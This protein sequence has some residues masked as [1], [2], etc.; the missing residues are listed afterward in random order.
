MFTTINVFPR[1]NFLYLSMV[2]SDR[3]IGFIFPGQIQNGISKPLFICSSKGSQRQSEK[4]QLTRRV[5]GYAD[6][7]LASIQ[8]FGI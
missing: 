1:R 8:L 3:V 6:C 5:V 2:I 4:K 7:G